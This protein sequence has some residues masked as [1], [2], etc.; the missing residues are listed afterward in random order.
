[1]YILSVCVFARARA[2]V[3]LSIVF[4]DVVGP[5]KHQGCADNLNAA[6]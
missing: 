5:I 2:C 1:M 6:C 4:L 3:Y